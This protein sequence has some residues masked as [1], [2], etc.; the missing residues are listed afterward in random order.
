M[1]AKLY[2]QKGNCYD[3]C[4]TNNETNGSAHVPICTEFE[5]HN[6]LPLNKNMNNNTL[7]ALT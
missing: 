4:I 1:Y 5:P 3:I 2:V 7:K 6:T